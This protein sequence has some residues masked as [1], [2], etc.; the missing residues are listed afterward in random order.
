MATTKTDETKNKQTDTKPR[1]SP[2]GHL[3]RFVG[4]WFGFAGLYG[5]FSVCP[6][7]S[8]QAC[9]VGFTSAGIFGAVF[10]LFLQDWR[11]LLMF[12]KA[13]RSK[14]KDKHTGGAK[15]R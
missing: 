15:Q 1:L 7:C 13:K 8:Q 2:L 12:I 14:C 5:A 3:L 11:R 6:F 4:W 10:S 9:P